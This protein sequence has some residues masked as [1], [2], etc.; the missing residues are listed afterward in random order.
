M[1]TG[2]AI[3]GA[4]GGAIGTFVAVREGVET[5][6]GDVHTLK[7][8]RDELELK[9]ITLECQ[10]E[11]L[12]NW[13]DKWMI[14]HEDEDSL[15]HHHLWG[16]HF[17]QIY[18]LLLAINGFLESLSSKLK[19]PPR[20][21]WRRWSFAFRYTFIRKKLI[22]ADLG[23]LE[24]LISHLKTEADTA[25]VRE[26]RDQSSGLIGEAFQ[27]VKLAKE[28]HMSSEQLYTTCVNASTETVLELDLNFFHKESSFIG[29]GKRWEAERKNPTA[30]LWAISASAKET[31]LHFTCL[32]AEKLPSDPLIRI[33]VMSDSSLDEHKYQR[34]LPRALGSIY[35]RETTQ[36]GFD[37][38]G[39]GP[40]YRFVIQES[41]DNRT[42]VSESLRKL[43]SS[44]HQDDGNAAPD[45]RH[46]RKLKVALDLVDYGL[47]FLQTSW[48]SQLCSCALRRVAADPR[49]RIHTVRVTEF[50]H[51][52]LSDND[53]QAS[54]CWGTQD[55]MQGKYVQRLGVLLVEL[56]LER[57]VFG[58]VKTANSTD[59]QLRF[60][61]QTNALS[62]SD[63]LKEAGVDE[64]YIRVVIYCLKCTWTR[65]Q[66]LNNES[67]LGE[68][69][70]K[71]LQP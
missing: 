49:E 55:F 60:V 61:P 62:L 22:A 41:S 56:A 48:L 26:H 47:L 65:D 3:F 71:I 19:K 38:S 15:L 24:K 42:W 52:T 59:L 9:R 27:L 31:K 57:L 13:R 46:L 8:I 69:Y 40:T 39:N 25:F 28:T 20:P 16:N 44:S 5:I 33:H 17:R 7:N 14:W 58:V 18:N 21:Y 1:A 4:I 29:F 50:E 35:R 34:T 53:G 10:Y 2:F 36:N 43:L 12:I 63:Q 37:T 45:L 6:Y 68:Y 67:L 54:T 66:V 32:A 51:M 23:E 11:S 70:W 64:A 30:R